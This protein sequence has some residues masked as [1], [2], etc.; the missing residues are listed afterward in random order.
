MAMNGCAGRGRGVPAQD[1]S[2]GCLCRTKAR[3]GEKTRKNFSMFPEEDRQMV[4]S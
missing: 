1:K 4:W 3:V 2:K